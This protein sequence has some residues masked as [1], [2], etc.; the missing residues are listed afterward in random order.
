[1]MVVKTVDGV[2]YQL[3]TAKHTIKGGMLKSGTKYSFARMNIGTKGY[4]ILQDGRD[5]T[6][7]IVKCYI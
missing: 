6:L 2:I 5:I 4:I 7:P 3:D 1:M